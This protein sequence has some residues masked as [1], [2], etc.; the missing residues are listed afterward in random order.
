MHEKIV[1]CNEWRHH[2]RA[3]WKAVNGNLK[4][5]V[6]GTAKNFEKYIHMHLTHPGKIKYDTMKLS[7]K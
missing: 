4:N 5:A 7:P 6:N 3:F 2:D 1:Q